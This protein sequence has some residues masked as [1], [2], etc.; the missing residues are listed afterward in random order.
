MAVEA[1]MLMSGKLGA[2]QEGGLAERSQGGR[3]K[4][5]HSV[6]IWLEVSPTVTGVTGADSLGWKQKDGF[7]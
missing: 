3:G 5:G 4:A 7:L 6:I 1:R 2:D